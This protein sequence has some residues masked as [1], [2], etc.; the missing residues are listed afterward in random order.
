[1]PWKR[2]ASV[3]NPRRRGDMAATNG[4]F[5][6]PAVSGTVKSPSRDELVHGVDGQIGELCAAIRKSK[7]HFE[8]TDGRRCPKPNLVLAAAKIRRFTTNK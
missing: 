1:M 2:N 4:H 8:A 5:V 6:Y 7:L 3:P